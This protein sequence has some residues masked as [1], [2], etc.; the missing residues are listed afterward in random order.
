MKLLVLGAG[1]IGGYFGGRLAQTGTDVT[2]LVRPGRREQLERDGL[3]IESP[4]GD[5]NMKVTTVLAGE[6]SAGYDIVL[7]TCKAYDLRSAMD[8]IAPAMHG[9]C[10]VVP[11]LNGMDHLA[12]L[13]ERFGAEKVMGGACSISVTL[14]ADGVIHHADALQRIAFG[15]RDRVRSTRVQM[16]ADTFA[17][18]AVEW[19][20]ADDIE[21][22]MWEKICFL[23]AMA[24]LTCLFRANIGEILSAPGGAEAIERTLAVNFAIAARA[25]HA[26]RQASMDFARTTLNDPASRR[27]ASMLHDMETGA[28]VESDH[29]VGWMLEQA[30]TFGLD[31][32][33]LSVAYTHL[34]AYEARRDAGRLRS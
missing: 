17:R 32:T 28:R 18:T 16:L 13:D 25:G 26:P 30:R 4:V 24:G 1:G 27:T 22:N 10:A 15:E 33:M 6:L 5:L 34:K 8:A 31:D 11:M 2:F 14:D 3:R 23:S 20:L 29:I 12:Q 21:Q 7:L 19:E 9:G